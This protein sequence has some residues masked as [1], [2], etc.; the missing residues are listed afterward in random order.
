[1]LSTN[2]ALLSNLAAP[3]AQVAP[4]NLAATFLEG[5][6]SF[7]SPCVLPLVPGYLSFI[8]GVSVARAVEARVDDPSPLAWTDTRRVL[9]AITFFIAGFTTVF[10]AIFGLT[11]TIADLLGTDIKPYVQAI[12]GLA[13]IVMGLHF[14]GLFKLKFLNM[15]KRFHFNSTNK[16][17]GLLGAYL[18]GA[19]FAAGWS[20]C[21]G[22]F[23]S[24]ALTNALDS[25]STL[26][27]VGM[28][29]VYSAGL[30][31]PFLL[32]GLFMNRLLGF[33]ARVRRH[34]QI[35]EIA[36]GVLLLLIGFLI[37]SNNM[38][39]ITRT[40]GRLQG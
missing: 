1:M 22:P 8:S 7:G 28:M 40:L 38:T 10:I 25:Q 34:Y 14:I 16:P 6:L 18:V 24:A 27:G 35:I 31:I 32:A 9:T 4:V 2:L 26:S 33:I 19:G 20:P 30:G 23:L 21:I 36:S 11:Y 37:I 17:V 3:V 5:V 15:E 12:A 39:E 29:L 13:V